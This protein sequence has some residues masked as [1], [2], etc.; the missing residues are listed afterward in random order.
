MNSTISCLEFLLHWIPELWTNNNHPI[1]ER[2]FAEQSY[3][4]RPE[5]GCKDALKQGEKLLKNGYTWAVEADIRRGHEMYD[6]RTQQKCLRGWYGYFKHSH[7]T[8]FPRIDSWIRMRLRSILRKRR[9]GEG[10]G[11]GAD[12][13]RWPNAYFA[14]LGLF[15][16]T[17]AHALACQSRMGNH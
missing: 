12:H 13:Q 16:L 8:T 4:F 1:F 3:G 17:A 5:R 2:T 9:G 7:K 15:P 11:R 6:R 14:N 10:R